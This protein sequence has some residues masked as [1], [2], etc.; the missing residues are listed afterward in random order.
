MVRSSCNAIRLLFGK[1]F[2]DCEPKAKQQM[3][4]VCTEGVQVE[5][6]ECDSFMAFMIEMEQASVQAE[7]TTLS[8]HI[9]DTAALFVSW[10]VSPEVYRAFVR[11]AEAVSP[12]T[13]PKKIVKEVLSGSG[14]NL[15]A[16]FQ[17]FTNGKGVARM[18]AAM[19]DLSRNL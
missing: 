4:Q 10:V 14:A 16:V 8:R 15:E 11:D 1:G 7:G 6:I 19:G 13:P 3:E 5:W 17:K 9:A 12:E 2:Q 18:K